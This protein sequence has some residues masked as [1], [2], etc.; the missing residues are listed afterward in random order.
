MGKNLTKFLC[1]SRFSMLLMVLQYNKPRSSRA[2]YF[3]HSFL[4]ELQRIKNVLFS[5]NLKV[6]DWFWNVVVL[7][8]VYDQSISF[9][10]KIIQFSNSTETQRLAGRC[11]AFFHF[12][13][14]RTHKLLGNTFLKLIEPWMV[15]SIMKREVHYYHFLDFPNSTFN[16]PARA[17]DFFDKC[18]GQVLLNAAPSSA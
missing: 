8:A 3:G 14:A 15:I 9:N 4:D 18:D 1:Q 12:N 16:S 2:N 10:T 6:T 11:S 5:A 13:D 7:K 17:Y